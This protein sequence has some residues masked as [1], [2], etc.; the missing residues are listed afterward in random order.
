LI[1]LSE[2]DAITNP[3]AIRHY[4][5]KCNNPNINTLWLQDRGHADFLFM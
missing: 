3:S 4:I 5:E 2:K 1:V